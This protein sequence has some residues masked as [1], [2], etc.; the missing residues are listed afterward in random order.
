MSEYPEDVDAIP[1]A[2]L[3]DAYGPST[4]TPGLLRQLL[5]PDA[6]AREEA[7]HELTTTIYHQGTVYES[8]LHAIAPLAGFLKR[9][10]VPDP[11][12]LLRLLY[13]IGTGGGWHTAHQHFTIVQQAFPANTREAEIRKEAENDRRIHDVLGRYLDLFLSRLRHPDENV[14][15]ES[16]KMLTIFPEKADVLK[17]PLQELFDRD[18]SVQVRANTLLI[19]ER[20]LGEEVK[21]FASTVFRSSEPGLLKTVAALQWAKWKSAGAPAEA[22]AYLEHVT[23]SRGLETMRDYHALPA[24]GHF[25][26]AAATCFLWAGAATADRQVP[27]YIDLMKRMGHST[28]T[29]TAL[30]L[31]AFWRDGRLIDPKAAPLTADQR[32][33]VL[34]VA[35]NTWSGNQTFVNMSNVLQ[36][37][38]LPEFQKPMDQF[39][40]LPDATHPGFDGPCKQAVADFIKKRR[41]T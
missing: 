14:R 21:A 13:L 33:A 15:M 5:S 11:E 36:R 25:W 4:R 31:L 18:G 20:L 24:A 9:D 10:R 27:R 19:L 39:L 22:V 6:A 28:D 17:G 29:A 16:A 40:G 7:F 1:W 32:R 37:F 23:E 12:V 35:E 8:S 34:V 38:G 3:P 30:L 2:S 41:S 26:L